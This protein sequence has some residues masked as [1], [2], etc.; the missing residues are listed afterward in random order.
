MYFVIFL[1]FFFKLIKKKIKWG[2]SSSW[3]PILWWGI[4]ALAPPRSAKVRE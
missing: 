2:T 1:V 4:P 3:D